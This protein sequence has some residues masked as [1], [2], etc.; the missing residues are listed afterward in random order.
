MWTSRSL[1]NRGAAER[2]ARPRRLAALAV[3]AC[4]LV[5]GTASAANSIDELDKDPDGNPIIRFVVPD[6]PKAAPTIS[7]VDASG[8]TGSL[9]DY[10]GKITAVHFWATWCAP[11]RIELPSVDFLNGSLSGESFAIVPISVDRDGP[12]A[13]GAFY[14]DNG[15]KSL[16]VFVDDG[17]DA[18][19]AFKLGGIPATIFLDAEGREIARVLGERDWS[20]PD[21]AAVVR[22]LIA[23]S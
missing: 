21:V 6:E 22:K 13:V 1:P 16:P 10:R 17:L 15:I 5:A 2:T 4:L 12:E 11:C 9:S 14:K 8:K 3:A 7:F 18:F 19:R 23:G 20:D